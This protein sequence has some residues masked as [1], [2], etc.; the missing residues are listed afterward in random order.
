MNSYDHIVESLSDL[1]SDELNKLESK[2]G[3]MIVSK[4]EEEEAINI[5][6]SSL[7]D[8]FN[9]GLTLTFD[10]IDFSLDNFEERTARDIEDFLHV[11]MMNKKKDRTEE[12]DN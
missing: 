7:E 9:K 5:F 12:E 1:S 4:Q 11:I 8:Y 6:L 2:I 10:P 3:E